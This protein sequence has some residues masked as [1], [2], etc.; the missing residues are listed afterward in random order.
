M[1]LVSLNSSNTALLALLVNSQTVAASSNPSS[2][3]HTVHQFDRGTWVENVAI[4][5]N[6]NL[7]VTLTDRPELHEIHP[8]NTASTMLVHSFA[9]YKSLLG[10]TEARTGVFA[11][12]VGNYSVSTGLVDPGAWSVWEVD[13]TAQAAPAISKIVD[14]PDAGLLNGMTTLNKDNGIILVSDSVNGEV[15]RV[16][17]LRG[18][19]ALALKHELFLPPVN[20]AI[21]IGINGIKYKE[22]SLYF[23]NTFGTSFGMV[24]IDPVYGKALGEPIIISNTTFGDDFALGKGSAFV[25]VNQKNTLVRVVADGTQVP[26]AG[27]TNSTLLPGLTSAAFGRTR[28][29]DNVIYITTSGGISNPVNG[30]YTE[31][32]KVVAVRMQA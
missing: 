11:V 5:D 27:G 13:Y 14:L 22:G 20:A 12:V 3:V 1:K 6:G 23:V 2:D 15:Y 30:V 16:D 28:D 26:V 7:L 24:Q 31:G 18:E 10:I 21:P 19:H 8:F 9:G 4:R 29:D 25:A 17:T 32:G